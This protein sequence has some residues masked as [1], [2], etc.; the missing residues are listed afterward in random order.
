M[1][2]CHYCFT[3]GLFTNCYCL[4]HFCVFANELDLLTV[5]GSQIYSHD[6]TLSVFVV[7]FMFC[8]FCSNAE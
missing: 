8:S 4:N 5:I 7:C 1:L 6:F 3:V 2:W